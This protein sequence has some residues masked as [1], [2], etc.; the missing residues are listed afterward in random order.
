MSENVGMRGFFQRK[1]IFDFLN[2]YSK[3]FNSHFEYL[4]LSKN[5]IALFAL[6]ALFNDNAVNFLELI[7]NIIII[8]VIHENLKF[9]IEH[10][11]LFSKMPF[12]QSILILSSSYNFFIQSLFIE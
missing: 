12:Y 5:T 7:K 3:I 11:N 2:L 6:F 4:I 10:Q 9:K 1:Q 8:Y